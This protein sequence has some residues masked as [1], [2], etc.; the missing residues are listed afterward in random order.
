LPARTGPGSRW[1]GDLSAS[2]GQTSA[3]AD[4]RDV[5][6]PSILTDR[7]AA[8][9]RV[10]GDAVRRLNAATCDQV[11]RLQ[12][13]FHASRLRARCTVLLARPVR[14]AEHRM[15]GRGVEMR[16]VQSGFTL[17]ELMI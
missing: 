6:G 12:G 10:T 15:T 2:Q 5:L 1:P 13:E 11:R 8:T 7:L 9:K 3:K 17:I 16:Q 14:L 4:A